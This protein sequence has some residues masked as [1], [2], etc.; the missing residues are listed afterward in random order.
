MVWVTRPF[1]IVLA[2]LILSF[3]VCFDSRSQTKHSF[4][5]VSNEE[6]NMTR[7][8]LDTTAA[9]VILFD[10]GKLDAF[11]LRFSRHL[12]VKVLKE[13]GVEWGN[14]VFNT[15]TKSDFKVQVFNL[16]GGEVTKHKLESSSVYTEKVFDDFEVYKVFA[17][18][19]KKGSVID[20]FYSFV[21]IPLEW[22]FQERIPIVLSELVLE[23]V[24]QIIFSKT[25]FGFH[26]IE[27]LSPDHWRATRVPSFESEPFIGT[28]KNYLT[29]FEFQIEKIRSPYFSIDFSSSWLKV[30]ENLD[31]NEFFGGLT[32]GAGFLNDA[33]NEI[34]SQQTDDLGR[35]NAAYK[36]IQQKIKW[37][38]T[39]GIIAD[40]EVKRIFQVSHSGSGAD[41]NLLLIAL[42]RKLDIDVL[43]VVLSTRSNGL[44]LPY[45]PALNKLNHVIGFIRH[46]ELSMFVDAIS[47]ILR[48]GFLPLECING[49]GLVINRGSEEWVTLATNSID[50]KTQHSDIEILADGT[51]Q[52]KVIR[53]LSQYAFV[54]WAEKATGLNHDVEMIKS[55][56]QKY[57]SDPFIEEYQI[58][59]HEPDRLVAKD[60]FQVDAS[61]RLIDG[62]AE[63]FF[64]PIVLFDYQSNPLQGESRKYPIDLTVPLNYTYNVSVKIPANFEV[65]TI[66]QPKKFSTLDNAGQFSY[67]SGVVGSVIQIRVNLKLTRPIF[68]Q[69]EYDDLKRFFT[70]VIGVVKE[71]VKL[72][73]KI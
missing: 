51:V 63:F 70:E 29:R 43:P 32:R 44:V 20:I 4:G 17:P 26:P 58:Q 24:D 57:F 16:S 35:I 14:W 67:A 68:T 46:K 60:F 33:A 55:D 37:N 12:R 73:K 48:P 31:S 28:Y 19:V 53:T 21:G 41:I 5:K 13:T 6:L 49:Q 62:G 23:P 27:T 72:K 9:A 38:K 10:I 59:S 54:N 66:P 1:S 3:F 11:S 7:Y 69:S 40:R 30:V 39:W 47:E 2:I 61:N 64:E 22:R 15:P 50:Q 42:L 52:A 56:Y 18:N 36:F 25:A 71:P 45:S 8:D 34:K 65:A